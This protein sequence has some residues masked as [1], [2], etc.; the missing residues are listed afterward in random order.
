MDKQKYTK[1]LFIIEQ[2]AYNESIAACDFQT[3]PNE[4]LI[5]KEG[6]NL[7]SNNDGH[8]AGKGILKNV[9]PTTVFNDGSEIGKDQDGCEYDWD[10]NI[11]VQ[12]GV[13]FGESFYGIGAGNPNHVPAY[14]G[15]IMFS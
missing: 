6:Q 1:P 7:C 13:S 8:T 2:Y 3:D 11:V 4:P 12:T 15:G 10:G 14:D 5:I 9:F